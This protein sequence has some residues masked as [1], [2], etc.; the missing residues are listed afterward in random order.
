MELVAQGVGN[1]G[2]ALSGAIP[3]TGA[4][5]G[6]AANVRSGGRTPAA[7]MVHAVVLLAVLVFLMPYAALIPMPTIAAILL[8]VACNMS[9]WAP[10]PHRLARRRVNA[11]TH[12]CVGDRARPGFYCSVNAADRFGRLTSITVPF[13]EL[14][15]T[16]T[17]PP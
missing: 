1:I 15:S 6:M 3:A 12:V 9:G 8:Q 4:I 17:A 5:A 13:S 7:G 16:S 2:S 10:V 11:A 14:A